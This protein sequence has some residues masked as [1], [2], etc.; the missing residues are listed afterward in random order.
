MKKPLLV[1][2][3]CFISFSVFAEEFHIVT[4]STTDF[5]NKLWYY[6]SNSMGDIDEFL[7]KFGFL[8]IERTI[9][10][11]Q[12]NN[13]REPYYS[14]CANL[15]NR[16]RGVSIPDRTFCIMI[17]CDDKYGVMLFWWRDTLSF[18]DFPAGDKLMLR[19]FFELKPVN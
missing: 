7:N 1:I 3:L 10:K 17:I 11:D 4:D 18:G 2:F 8:Y 14:I 13:L 15:L 6:G 19:H 9:A 5:R 12:F 16:G